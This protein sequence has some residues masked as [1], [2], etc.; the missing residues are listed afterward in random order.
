MAKLYTTKGNVNGFKAM[1]ASLYNGTTLQVPEN[2]T[3][4]KHASTPE[5]LALSPLGKVPCLETACG[6]T[7]YEP[8]A[9]LRYVM[10]SNLAS[11]LY[12]RCPVEQAQVDQFIDFAATSLEPPLNTWTYPIHGLCKYNHQLVEQA[13]K[14]VPAALAFLD[15]HLTTRTFLVG[16]C[17]T[18]ADIACAL[19]ML[20]ASKEVFDAKFRGGYP[21]VFRWFNTCVNQPQFVAVIGQTTLCVEAKS[22][23]PAKAAKPAKEKQPKQPQQPKQPKAPKA[24]KEEDDEPAPAPKPK[25]DNPLDKLPKSPM[26]LDEWKKTYS[27]NAWPVAKKWLD[28]NFDKE[29]WCWYFCRYQYPMDFKA[30][31]N[32]NNLINGFLQRLDPL[33]KYGFGS[34]VVTGDSSTGKPPFEIFGAWMFRGQEVPFEMTDC[35]DAEVYDF[36]PIDFN[37][38]EHVTKWE[39]ICAAEGPFFETSP[40]M[41]CQTWKP[42]K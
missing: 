30:L 31:F 18:G 10:R 5:Y 29:G 9:I 20:D 36:E 22:A 26:S 39:S 11:Q 12:G 32:A 4:E 8:N 16:E 42:Y 33:R 21:N 1:V 6:H 27:N 25:R 41:E 40:A 23:K 35:P 15:A 7:V 24:P 34:M 3:I 14:D 17:V 2:F 13:M 37:N 28:D 38:S 19:A